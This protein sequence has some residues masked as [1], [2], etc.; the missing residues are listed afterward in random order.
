MEKQSQPEKDFRFGLSLPET[1]MKTICCPYLWIRTF[2]NSLGYNS[3]LASH[4]SK[5]V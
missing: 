3:E 2:F 5:A 4:A 1:S